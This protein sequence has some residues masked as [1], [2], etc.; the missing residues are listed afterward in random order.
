MYVFGCGCSRCWTICPTTATPAVRSS[1]CS[2]DRSSPFSS[3]AMQNAR[4]FGRP[5]AASL[6]FR[7][8]PVRPARVRCTPPSLVPCP[9]PQAEVRTLRGRPYAAPRHGPPR[10]AAVQPIRGRRSRPPAA[11][12]GRGSAARSR[13]RVSH[14]DHAQHGARH[15]ARR[16]RGRGA[17][18]GRHAQRRRARRRRRRRAALASG[19][20]A[21]RPAR[22]ARQ[23]LRPRARD[24]ARP[25]GRVRGDRVRNPARGR[26]RRRRRAHVRRHRIARDRR[27]GQPDRERR[28]APRSVSAVPCTCTRRCGALAASRPPVEARDVRAPASTASR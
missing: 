19:F 26:R 6:V 22:R 15:R 5:L 23:R 9:A 16:R 10:R 27:R 3:A 8:S 14:R 18:D 25:R 24:P 21:R 17:R 7:S 12:E 11:A 4:C 1:S 13:H 28:P 20:A 2:S